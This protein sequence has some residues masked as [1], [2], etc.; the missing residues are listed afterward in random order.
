MIGADRVVHQAQHNDS[1]E[2]DVS[3][4]SSSSND[5]LVSILNDGAAISTDVEV[6]GVD[7]ARIWSTEVSDVPGTLTEYLKVHGDSSAHAPLLAVARTVLKKRKL[8]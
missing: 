8:N 6:D 3:S 4:S 5:L 2:S 7:Q 1:D